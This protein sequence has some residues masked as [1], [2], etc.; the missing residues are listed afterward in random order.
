MS[1]MEFACAYL[2]DLPIILTEEGFDKQ[3]RARLDQIVQT[4]LKNQ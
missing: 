3:T 4:R 2:D 1:G